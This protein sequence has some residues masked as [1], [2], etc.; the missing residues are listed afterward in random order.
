MTTQLTTPN[1]HHM[2]DKIRRYTI[3]LW[4]L[5]ILSVFHFA[6]AAPVAPG[7]ILAVRSKTVDVLKDGIAAWEKRMD[8]YEEP[9]HWSTNEAYRKDNK[10]EKLGSESP[11][12]NQDQIELDWDS[13]ETES[14]ARG[15][16]PHYNN[17]LGDDLFFDEEEINQLYYN[18]GES[19]KS[20]NSND[21]NGNGNGGHNG[22]D[23]GDGSNENGNSG[24]DG[25]SENSDETVQSEQASAENTNMGP[26]S[27]HPAIPEHLTNLEKILKG[28]L[29]FRPRNS[30]SGAV[31]TPKR[32]CREPL[33]VRR[34]VRPLPVAS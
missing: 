18:E 19:A 33:T 8:F 20:D 9:D 14:D 10:E 25:D 4:I 24:Y 1:Q 2:S 29:E 17:P 34:L 21:G 5:L 22:D 3:A 6:L 31:G 15:P 12:R 23:N 16:D 11:W 30:G 32:G 13:D 26:K 28:A 7:E 27:E